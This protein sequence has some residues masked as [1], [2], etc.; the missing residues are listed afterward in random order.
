[1]MMMMMMNEQQNASFRKLITT[2]S[3]HCFNS[4]AQLVTWNIFLYY[5]V[6]YIVMYQRRKRY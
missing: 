1:M 3:H 4:V 2:I 6:N 5:A